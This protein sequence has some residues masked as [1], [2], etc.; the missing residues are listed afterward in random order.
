MARTQPINNL[1]SHSKKSTSLLTVLL[2]IFA[3]LVYSILFPF[4]QIATEN[5][6]PA[7][8]Y[9]VWLSLGGGALMLLICKVSGKLPKLTQRHLVT[10]IIGGILSISAPMS[11]LALAAAK[12]PSS[13]ITM[14][15]V[16]SPL[17]S[18]LFALT[19][20]LDTFRWLGLLGFLCGLGGVLLILVPDASLPDPNMV[21]WVLITLLAPVFLALF[22]IF[23]DTY[24]PPDESSLR[25]G[26]G[27]LLAA[28]II[29][30]PFT[31]L[32]GDFH[33]FPGKN[34]EGDMAILYATIINVVRWW[35]I[36]ILI[37]MAGAVFVSQIAYVIVLGGFG[38][39]ALFFGSTVSS[40]IWGAA[41]LL[42]IGLSVN[43][44]SKLQKQRTAINQ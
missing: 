5:S 11:L 14:I 39:Q 10:Y 31:A 18:Y 34:T 43:T 19:V 7:L 27:I 20:K 4:N 24:A 2:L 42:L 1:G 33:L 30:L 25:L 23:I 35:L 41:A 38:W 37:K 29:M 40:F 9:V 36:F 22:N 28:G 21:T 6:V 32:L 13:V 26:T 8:G 17:L 15:V 44:Y 16:L 12:L 3:G